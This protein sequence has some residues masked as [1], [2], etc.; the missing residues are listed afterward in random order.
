MGAGL[1]EPVGRL[2]FPGDV[3]GSGSD[4]ALA[5]GQLS[6]ALLC[7]TGEQVY[8]DLP[9]VDGRQKRK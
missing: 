7:L 6:R 5:G 4:M 1:L 3:M 2:C 9:E 8:I